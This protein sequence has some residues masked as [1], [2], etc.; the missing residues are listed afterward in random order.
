VSDATDET[1]RASL[2]AAGA[3][4]DE[5]TDGASGMLGEL[6]WRVLWPPKRLGTVPP[7]NAA[8]VT[9]RFEGVGACV[10]G[11]L[12]ALFLGDL[13]EESQSRLLS[14]ARPSPVDV[15][16]VAH[17]GSADQSERLYERIRARVG[18][19]SVGADNRYGHP[20]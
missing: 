16:K 12:S 5:V 20:T 19:I 18:V 14:T 13:G 8:S 17:H 6:R 9:V 1:L 10:T 15:V 4:V 2:V 3:E 11:C 7:G